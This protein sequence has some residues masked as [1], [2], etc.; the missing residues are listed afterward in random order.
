MEDV[1]GQQTHVVAVAQSV[2]LGFRTTFF[3]GPSRI[4][5]VLSKVSAARGFGLV[6]GS[7]PSILTGQ[8]IGRDA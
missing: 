5:V 3:H 6:G 1:I 8:V 7:F 4:P 2:Q